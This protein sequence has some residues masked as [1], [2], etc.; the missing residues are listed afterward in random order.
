MSS[1]PDRF[2]TAELRAGVLQAWRNSPT[3]FTEDA[4]AEEDLRLGGYAD[5]LFV[6]LAQNAA[7][8]AAL[9][10]VPGELAIQVVDGELRVANTGAGLDVA[11]VAALASLRASAKRG[12]VTVGRFG[13]G[14]A[15]VLA[16][17]SEPRVVSSD[18]GVCFS[19]ARTRDVAGAMPELASQFEQR[20]GAVPVLRLVWPAP[21]DEAAVPDGFDTEV[22]L[23]LRP[24]VD[25]EA[26]LAEISDEVD[27]VLLTL[28]VLRRIQVGSAVWT[29]TVAAD[30]AVE[31]AAEGGQTRRWR[32]H[33]STGEFTAAQAATL[34]IEAAKHPRWSVLWALPIDHDGVPATMA[35]DV[36]HAPTATDERLSLPARLIATAPIEPSRRRVLAGQAVTAVFE[37]AANAYVDLVRQVDPE[38]RLELVPSGGFPLSE[39]DAQLRELITDRLRRLPWLP[40]A[41]EGPD[42]AGG[43][44]RVLPTRSAELT[45]LLADVVPG[46][47]Q[48]SGPDAVR[49]LGTAGADPLA[50]ADAVDE[51]AGLRRSAPWWCRLY[52]ALLAVLEAREVA[53]EE[54]A[55]LSVALVDGRTVSG[56]RGVLLPAFGAG[57]LLELLASADIVGLRVADPAVVHPLLERLGASPVDAV[58]LLEADALRTAVERSVTDALDG[59]DAAP[60][61]ELVLRLVADTGGAQERPWLGALALTS[62]DG[63]LRRADELI[64][65]SSDLLEVLD[66]DEVGTDGPLAVLSSALAETWPVDVLT[67][68]GVLD[69]FAVVT[70]AEPVGPDHE[71][72][73]EREFWDAHEEP[74][75]RFSA[76]RDLDLVA[77]DAWPA[78]LRLLAGRRETWRAVAEPGGYTS[79]WLARFGS[80]SGQ[81]PMNWRLPDCD[82]LAGLYD[83]VPELGLSRDVLAAAGVRGELAVSDVADAADLLERLADPSRQ[84]PQGVILRA[85]AALASAPGVDVSR[86]DPP[87]AVRALDGSVTD[88]ERACVLD[89]PW[90]LEVVDPSSLVAT[91]GEPGALADLLD[92]PRASEIIEGEVAAEGEFAAWSELGAVC[93]AAE[94]LGV[95][96]PAGGVVMHGKL[97]VRV[98]GETRTAHWWVDESGG[99][100]TEDSEHGLARAFAHAAGDWQRRHLLAELLADPSAITLLG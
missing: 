21:A 95:A 77:A 40:A 35:A 58:E 17:S 61:V 28:P 83:P 14:F 52:D 80:L 98:N 81:S 66:P 12:G 29:R 50:V 49:V 99:V 72:P 1:L 26:L 19:A 74:P 6:E 45:E 89:Q 93:A 47:V 44:A 64:L 90:L 59:L 30:G 75:S 88:A 96:V 42:I 53:P 70:D 85:H 16:V 27:D 5:R 94:L 76:V 69:G 63:D 41:A 79:W 54:L 56:V 46:L 11:G 97:D 68:I 8:A 37:A 43:Q 24:D 18:G 31:I 9:A 78:A 33:E 23:P 32:V 71:V 38:H 51:L 15:A 84:P 82:E 92:L 20:E 39:V 10:K 100:H 25:A 22:R 4:N 34:G 3:R 36:L 60:L 67:A 2:G 48:P 65:P 86:L 13:V 62:S 73:D 91:A 87:D 55:G 57:E 7:D